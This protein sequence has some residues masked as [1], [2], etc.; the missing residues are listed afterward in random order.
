MNKMK[1]CIKLCDQYVRLNQSK[2]NINKNVNK[3]FIIFVA[4]FIE[5]QNTISITLSAFLFLTFDFK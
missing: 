5:I 2:Q 4:F 3:M 1:Q